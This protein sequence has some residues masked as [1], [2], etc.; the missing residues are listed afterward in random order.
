MTV[1]TIGPK[2]EPTLNYLLA[3]VQRQTALAINC[4]QIGTIVKYHA[5]NNTAKV[6]INFKALMKNGQE[7][8]YP[9]LDDCPVFVI[10][11]GDSS[12]SM[13]IAADDTCLVLFSDRN[14]DDWYL[15]GNIKIPADNR[16]HSIADGI[17]LVGIRSLAD[18]KVYPSIPTLD[19][20]SKKIAIKNDDTDLKTLMTS[21]NTT[22]NDLIDTIEDMNSKSAD[23]MT[24]IGA[25]TYLVDVS[26]GASGLPL[27]K[28]TFTSANSDFTGFNTELDSLKTDLTTLTTDI[29]KLLDEGALI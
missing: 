22:L 21:L 17:V 2:C 26:T 5:E 24:A 29:S 8:K 1:K 28:A 16:I 25:I 19:G 13:P 4:V 27:N 10:S 12:L 15:T 3:D 7:V 20:G 9:V 6:K 23:I 11:G 18:L 14:I